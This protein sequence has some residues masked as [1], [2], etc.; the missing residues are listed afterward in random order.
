VNHIAF[1]FET[2]YDTRLSVK[3]MIAE[4]YAMHQDVDVYM[5]SVA[6]GKNT[7]AGHPRDFNWSLFEGQT[8]IAHNAYF[9]WNVWRAMA[10][11]GLAPPPNFKE[12]HCSANL[13]SYL[14]NRRSLDQSVE[15]L[16]KTRISKAVRSDAKGKRWPHDFSEEEQKAMLDYARADAHWCWRIWEEFSDQWPEIE[17]GLSRITIEQGTRGIQVDTERLNSYIWTSHEM[18]ENTEK[19]IP[20]IADSVDDEEDMSWEDFNTKPTSSKCI[21]E[22]CRRDGIPCC[23][24]KRESIED[25]EEWESTYAPDHKWIYAVTQWRSVNKLHQAFAVM[26]ERLRNDGTMPFGLKYFGAHTGR[27]SGEARVNM[28][29][30]RKRPVICNEHGL[31]ETNP[32]RLADAYDQY[33]ETGKWPDWVLDT[34]DF[35]SLIIPRPG[36]RMIT[37]D[38]AQIEPR[39]LAW[40]ADDQVML[41]YFRQGLAA[42]DAHA[43][44]TMGWKGEGKLKQSDPQ[45]YQLAKARVLALGYGAGWRKF[46]TMA[47][48]TAGLDITKDDPEWIDVFDYNTNTTKKVPGYG[49][50]AREVVKEF[51]AS[52]KKVVE[53]WYHLEGAFKASVGDTFIMK[54][55]SGRRMNYRNVAKSIKPEFDK[56]TGKPI[57]RE[58]WTAESDGKRKHF[59]GGKLCENAVQA[60]SRDVFGEHIYSIDSSGVPCLFTVHDEGI[61]EVDKNVSIGDIK[62]EMSKCPD[63]LAGCPIDATVE[64]VE[65]YKK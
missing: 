55:P 42:Y 53:Y 33:D 25:Y 28:Q 49:K 2:Y 31:M 17:R 43:R 18:R 60:T 62:A 54:L 19:M 51:R 56:E 22:Q 5:L 34:L 32:K 65:R 13:T 57:Q 26:K 64:E 41:D 35:R 14:C 58:Q 39:V 29:N 6:D 40:L 12:L 52:N 37:A 44:A 9:D 21:A 10:E 48:S 4:Q 16:F 1:D 45:M 23:P 24:V 11:R 20:W 38:L 8:L 63:W 7:W 30:Q 46:I 3:K 47:L 36:K 50:H 27:W 59:Y 61:F 15:F